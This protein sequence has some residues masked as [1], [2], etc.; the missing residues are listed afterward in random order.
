MVKDGVQVAKTK[1][2]RALQEPDY[3]TSKQLHHIQS[4]CSCSFENSI[5]SNEVST[6]IYIVRLALRCLRT[7]SPAGT[8]IPKSRSFANTTSRYDELAVQSP[9]APTELDPALVSTRKEERQLIKLGIQPIGSRRRR[10]ALQSSDNIPF[11]QLPYQCFQE[12]R[13]ILVTDRVE[14]LKQIEVERKRIAKIQSLDPAQC[15][16]EVSKKGRLVAMY[17]YLEKLKIYADLNDPVIKKRFE[18]GD[19]TVVPFITLQLTTYMISRGYEQAN[20][21]IPSR[22]AMERVQTSP[23]HATYYPDECRSGHP[24]VSRSY[25]RGIGFF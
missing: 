16:G 15:G 21:S 2:W 23:T 17:K 4:S 18:D 20:L 19:G 25:S 3:W 22:P 7:S 1:F 24:S 9:P 10:A 6:T 12:A 14:K 11:E 5:M 13:K 8:S